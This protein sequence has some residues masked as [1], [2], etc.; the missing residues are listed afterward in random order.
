MKSK[1]HNIN[2]ITKYIRL[3]I[4]SFCIR[5][6]AIIFALVYTSEKISVKVNLY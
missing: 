1:Y 2:Y 3:E 6:K 4:F 5:E